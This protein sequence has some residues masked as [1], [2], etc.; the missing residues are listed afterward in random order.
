MRVS[1]KYLIS[2]PFCWIVS[3][4]IG[5][6]SQNDRPNIIFILTD[7]Q[8]WDALGCAGNNYIKTP[9]IDSLAHNGVHFTNAYVT[10]PI[11]CVSRASIFTGQY[12]SCNG[13]HDFSSGLSKE[14]L[15]ATYPMILKNAGYYVGFIGKYGVGKDK[16]FPVNSYDFWRSFPGQGKYWSDDSDLHL[17][18]LQGQQII[19]FLRT[20]DK[21]KNFCLSI[22]FKAP[23]CQDEMRKVKGGDEFPIDPRDSLLYENTIFPYPET[24]SDDYYELLNDNF[25]FSKIKNKENEARVRWK[26]RFSSDSLYQ[27]TVRKYY[28]LIYGVDR[29][30]GNLLDELEKQNIADNTIIVFMGDNGFFLGEHGLAG[31]WFSMEEAARVPLIVY[32]P[33]SSKNKG[34]K[35]NELVLNID[36]APTI[37]SFANIEIPKTMQ[38]EDLNI[39]L[40]NR[41]KEK[42][43]RTDFYCEYKYNPKFIHLPPMEAVINKNFKLTHYYVDG[44]QWYE[45]YDLRKDRNEVNNLYDNRRYKRVKNKMKDRMIE[46][47]DFVKK[48]ACF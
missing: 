26:F 10:S 45:L 44:C 19:E 23:H 46:L 38:G 36:I 1:E 33:R 11:S 32:D 43:W 7:D 37:L 2:L 9:N 6:Y 3:G 29:E 15:E 35:K 13:I 31:K 17:T 27:E 47:R 40:N 18:A 34:V 48:P 41:H 20:R 42:R 8:R 21:S 30:I 39:L 24:F 4:Y 22:S 25:K 16:D 12:A 5:V 28:T 14:Q